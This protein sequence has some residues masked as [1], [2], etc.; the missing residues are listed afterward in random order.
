MRKPALERF[1]WLVDQP[2]NFARDGVPVIHGMP[3]V[4]WM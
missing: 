2:K 4:P 1:H 3:M